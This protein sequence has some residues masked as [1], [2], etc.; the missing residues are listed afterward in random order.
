MLGFPKK[1]TTGEDRF[2]LAFNDALFKFG[3]LK[4]LKNRRSS[5]GREEIRFPKIAKYSSYKEDGGIGGK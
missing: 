4:S 1:I 2:K 3:K 5:F